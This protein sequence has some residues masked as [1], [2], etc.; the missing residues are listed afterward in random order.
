MNKLYKYLPFNIQ[1]KHRFE[2][3]FGDLASID[4]Y[5]NVLIST[6]M[7]DETVEIKYVRPVLRPFEDLTKELPL[8]KAAAEML[9]MKE[10]EVILV[11]DYISNSCLFLIDNNMT[12]SIRENELDFLRAMHF[13]VDFKEDEYIKLE[14]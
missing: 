13:A 6:H 4:V 3:Y 7:G 9:G 5:G 14:S 2:N 10:G 8:T 12:W 1:V 11:N